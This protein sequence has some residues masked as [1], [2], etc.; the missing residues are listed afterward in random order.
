MPGGASIE[1]AARKRRMPLKA[2][3]LPHHDARDLYGCDL[4]LIRPDQHVAWR[5]NRAPEDAEPMVA[6]M[7]FDGRA[8]LVADS[9][10]ISMTG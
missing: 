7:R 5:G 6:R 3:D 4:C 10:K 8:S 1:A 2:V 9:R